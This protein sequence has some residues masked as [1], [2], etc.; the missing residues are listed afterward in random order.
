M[1]LS[2][3]QLLERKLTPNQEKLKAFLDSDKSGSAYTSQ[4][5]AVQLQMSARDVLKSYPQLFES[6]RFRHRGTFYIASPAVVKE[7]QRAV[8]A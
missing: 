7:Y 6:Y 3:K 8:K 2:V 1:P 4:E 5:L